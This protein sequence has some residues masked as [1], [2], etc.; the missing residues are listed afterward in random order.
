[1]VSQNIEADAAV[2]VDVGMVDASGEVDLGRLERIVGRK[3]DG[4]EKDTA[5]V[6]RITLFKIVSNSLVKKK[7]PRQAACCE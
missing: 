2:G 1:M 6:G 5:R 3:V 7:K 4:E